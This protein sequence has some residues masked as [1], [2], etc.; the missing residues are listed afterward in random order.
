[1]RSLV[2][3]Q[4]SGAP[5]DEAR[6][7]L[8]FTDN[9]QDASLQAGHFN[10]FAQIALLRSALY[11]AA[12]SSGAEGLE[13]GAL[14]R[15]VFRALRLR[16]EE[17]AADPGVRGPARHATDDA[18]C[19]A[20]DYF[21]Y[22]DLKRGWRVTAPNLEDCG[23]LR[24]EYQGLTGADG[25]LGET[26]LWEEGFESGQGRDRECLETPPALRSCG[27]QLR[28]EILRT[29][30]D[31]LREQLA[32]DV[33]ALDRRKQ[34]ELV[35]RTKSRLLEGT[36]WSLDDP[37]E[38]ANSSVAYPRARRGKGPHDDKTGYF[39]S[40]RGALGQYVRRNLEE[41]ADPGRPF[42]REDVDRIIRF[43]FAALARYG[44][45]E[46]VRKPDGYRINPGALRWVAGD[47][48][49]RPLDR[50]RL[51]EAGEI[52]AQTNRYFLECYRSFVDLDCILEAREHTAQVAS[53]DREEREARFREGDL[54][55]LFCSPTMELGVDIA[56]LNLV[57]L[58]NVPPTPANYAQRSG[59][60]GRSGQ[61]ALVYTYCAGQSPHDQYYYGRPGDMV[62]GA[63]TP[64]R[65]DLRNRDLVRSHIHA[66]WM[67]VANP[68]F[69]PTL[70]SLIDVRRE[71]GAIPLPLKPSIRRSL[72]DPALRA[73]ALARA[74]RLAESIGPE[75]TAATWFREDW[76]AETLNGIVQSFETACERWRGLYRAAFR[77]RELH[78]G[79]IGD[80]SRPEGERAHSR[81]LRAQAESQI[82]LLTEA[83]GVYRGDFYS[84]RYLATEGFLPGYNF[85]R[86]PLSA[87]VP[88][89]RL[90]IDRDEF[91]SRPRFLAISEFGPRALVYHEGSRYRVYKVNLDFGSDGIESTHDL[92]TTTMKRCLRCGYAHV[93]EGVNF[94]ELCER[95]GAN[96]NGESL[97][98]DL[99]R[100]Q[101]VS[102]RPVQRITC[103]EE[104]R[105]RFGYRL[106]SAWRF[107][108]TG[109]KMDRSDSEVVVDDVCV[110]RLSYG[111]ATSL[112]RIN[113]GW[114]KRKPDQPD[115]F[116]LDLEKGYWSRN[117]ADGEDRDDAAAEGRKVRVVPW[118]IDTRNV[119]VVAFE[120]LPGVAE[121]AALQAAFCEAI[122]KRYQ[123][124]PR[125]LSAEA[126][127][128]PDDR[129]EILFYEAAEGGAGVLRQLVDDPGAI[130][131]LA[132]RALEICHFDPDTLEDLKADTCG[133]ACYECLLDYGNQPD[134][135]LLDRHA[136][137]GALAE[138][139]R[140]RARPAGG[141]GSRTERLAALREACDSKLEIRWLDSLDAQGLRLPSDAQ[142]PIEACSTR[143]DFFYR[144]YNAAV[145]VDGPPH[146]GEDRRRDDEA[147]T[148]RLMDAGYVVLR[149]HHAADW[150]G[151]FSRHPDIFGTARSGSADG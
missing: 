24:F 2:E 45:L 118:V 38:L 8:S 126:M 65:I 9:R 71:G 108:E 58:R 130:P 94:A 143:P 139:A 134:H 89:R 112:Y 141:P 21:L 64:P 95:C 69:G 30:L 116:V 115:G 122:R 40:S 70:T 82:K 10:D 18:L 44:I 66:V 93:A 146:D 136:I 26:E 73:A 76:V 47:G 62:A 113:L 104:E 144:D 17:Y 79:I 124:E 98:G 19:R 132:R 57:N 99:V 29:L 59:R 127:P 148:E 54:P 74:G 5:A 88:G 147:I 97:I 137:R 77:Q 72:N 119:L 63:V 138:L 23:L 67:E 43:L 100:M 105:Q 114:A 149:F 39:V 49:T 56:Q 78:H 128:S 102:L 135:M 106:V 22:R 68:D 42:G 28:E 32:I 46:R 142:L 11:K 61:P 53:E 140:S 150:D 1:M 107:P 120:P 35:R 85:P 117:E 125:E 4:G 52:P 87:Y 145:Y 6:K 3:L 101:N 15:S 90:R 31:A 86:L 37:G 16:F 91:I 36:V 75:L 51:L 96:L 33:D 55:L 103:D 7:L 92:L 109:G 83:E 25:L 13:H 121:M 133:K 129:R 14:A 81:R 50:T 48:E 111:D 80:A 20:I 34:Q 123:L 110:M 27:A 41:H 60:A 131:E 151:V 84:W 12:L